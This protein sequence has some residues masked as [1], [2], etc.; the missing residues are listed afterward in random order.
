[1][2]ETL[3]AAL[4]ARVSTAG[5]VKS[6]PWAS[7]PRQLEDMR[8][9]A[10]RVGLP[11]V[12][13]VEEQGS[14]RKADR[15][16]WQ[17][18]L[19]AVRAGTVNVIVAVAFDRLTRSPKLAEFETLA[20]ELRDLGVRLWTC[21]D[22]EVDLSNTADAHTNRDLKNVLSK[23]E[24]LVIRERTMAA[25]EAKARAGGYTGGRPPYGYLVQFDPDRG[26][27]F[28]VEHPEHAPVV[29]RV[30]EA[31]VEGQTF[32]AITR[33][34]NAEGIAPPGNWGK[35]RPGLMWRESN[36]SNLLENPTY[37]GLTSW[38]RIRGAAVSAAF[39]PIITPATREAVVDRLEL[40]KERGPRGAH[41]ARPLSGIVRCKTCQSGMGYQRTYHSPNANQYI[42]RRLDKLKFPEVCPAPQFFNVLKANAAVLA[43]LRDHL[44]AYIDGDL[45]TGA[46]AK[47]GQPKPPPTAPVEKALA[48]ARQ[49]Q[50]N[51]LTLLVDMDPSDPL[52]P[53]LR[54]K[55]TEYREEIATLEARLVEMKRSEVGTGR[56][57]KGAERWR[58]YLDDLQHP[59]WKDDEL[60][61][62]FDTV[63][64]CVFLV[65][66]ARPYQRQVLRVE[67]L[68]LRNGD[69][70]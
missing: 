66:E 67:R 28:F 41:A 22:G 43:Y 19:E 46:I 65:N 54:G 34:L 56:T 32:A 69:W 14:G 35:G 1:M 29:R 61:G 7:L 21:K 70:L 37:A 51:T 8:A 55:L 3:R 45:L 47:V 6:D 52:V 36:V 60:R 18:V 12:M 58:P 68:L 20:D 16:G 40:L 38:A 11:I 48:K 25:R 23:R 5:Q 62:L 13:E 26:T 42:C 15:A 2:P 33:M 57:R 44:A 59:D 49:R 24:A 50:A 17:R 4:Y 10:A 39:A 53:E 64:K 63:I 9:L 30:F 31:F 27:K